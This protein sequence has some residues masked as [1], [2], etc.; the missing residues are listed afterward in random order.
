MYQSLMIIYPTQ[1]ISKF[2][3]EEQQMI[4]E[5][6]YRTTVYYSIA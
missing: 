2:Y 1:V 4:P 5:R 6:P 3:L